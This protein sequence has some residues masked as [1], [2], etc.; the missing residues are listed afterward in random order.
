MPS[1]LLSSRAAIDQTPVLAVHR[2]D[3]PHVRELE[4]RRHASHKLMWAPVGAL[5]IQ[6]GGNDWVIPPTH[7]LWIPAGVLHGSRAL[8]RGA[9]YRVRVAPTESPVVWSQPTS[10]VVTPLM[11]E[12]IVY[13]GASERDPDARRDAELLLL[14]LIEA[15]PVD[16]I[17]VPLPRDSRARAVAEA[18]IDRPDDDR[19]LGAWG[20]EVGASIRTL[21]RLFAAETGMTFM[22]WRAQVRMR[23]ALGLLAD[24]VPVANVAR[25][26]G[27]RT[28]SAFVAAYR[29]I[30]GH[31]PGAHLS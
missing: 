10:V 11:R 19:D 27:Y 20:L 2:R 31:T 18:L 29:R 14:D 17:H 15:A 4:P 30:T 9:V 8:R 25:Q 28:P 12:L 5:A 22:Q 3:V 13:L 21:A 7:A 16:T 1:M 24:G 26:V 6:A 23:A